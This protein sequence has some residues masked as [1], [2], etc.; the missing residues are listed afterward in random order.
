MRNAEWGV[1]N[2]TKMRNAEW[3][4]NREQAGKRGRRG[5]GRREG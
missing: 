1:R 5:R 2:L 4:L 3:L